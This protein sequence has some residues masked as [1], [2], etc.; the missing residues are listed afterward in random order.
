MANTERI[1]YMAKNV[2]FL[3]FTQQ[4]TLTEDECE[5]VT[6]YRSLSPTRKCIFEI[7]IDEDKFRYHPRNTD[8]TSLDFRYGLYS[9]IL[10]ITL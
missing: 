10:K 6:F 4:H 9:I 2:N 3:D 5:L 1:L 7:N 8:E